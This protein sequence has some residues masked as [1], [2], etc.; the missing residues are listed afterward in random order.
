MIRRMAEVLNAAF[1]TEHVV[2]RIGGDE[3]AAILP[4]MD[5]ETA[6]EITKQIQTLV[7]M[8]NKYYREPELS[9]SVGVSTSVPGI[10]LEKV[11]GMADD[12]MYRHKHESH[13][14][15]KDDH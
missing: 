11:I 15:R 2:A 9:V 14:R 3:F 10:S 6:A 4:D 1:D 5:E 13:H 7:A 8:N 12:A